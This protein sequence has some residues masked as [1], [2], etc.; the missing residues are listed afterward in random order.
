M[1]A[2]FERNEKK[3]KII[4]DLEAEEEENARTQERLFA[5]ARQKM[6][7]DCENRVAEAEKDVEEMADEMAK[8]YLEGC[9]VTD[10]T[11]SEQVHCVYKII[12]ASEGFIRDKYFNARGRENVTAVYR[13]LAR[14][15]H[16]DKNKHPFA[17]EA[18]LKISSIYATT[19]SNH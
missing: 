6:Q 2:N 7:I 19:M 5:E 15:L 10:N 12:C 16:P 3:N 17:N 9:M 11:V 8:V 4:K 18:F 1:C 13:H 14:N